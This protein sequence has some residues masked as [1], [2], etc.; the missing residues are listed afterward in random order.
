M[1]LLLVLFS[2]G[3]LI[4]NVTAINAS[5][6][7]AWVLVATGSAVAAVLVIAVVRAV[8]RIADGGAE[9]PWWLQIVELVLVGLAY[10]GTQVALAAAWEVELQRGAVLTV[11][12][13]TLEVTVIGAAVL[14]LIRSRRR[15]AAIRLQ[16]LEEAV[17]LSLARLEV[18]EIVQRMQWALQ[19]DIDSTLAAA[20]RSIEEQLEV[21]ERRTAFERWPAI[22]DHLRRTANDTVRPLSRRLWLQSTRDE[23]PLSLGRILRNVITTQPFRPGLLVLAYLATSLVTAVAGAGWWTALMVMGLGILLI[24]VI[25]GSA[26]RLMRR[27]PERHALLFITAAV[28]LELTGL[29][30]FPLRDRLGL[31][32]YTWGEFA[33]A[34]LVGMVFILM[35]SA[36]GSIRTYQQDVARTFRHDLDREFVDSL[37]AGR[38]VAQLAR[39]SARILHGSVQTRLVACAVAV[40][41]AAAANDPEA[42]RSAL[43]E[44]QEALTQPVSSLGSDSSSLEEEVARKVGLWRGLCEVSVSIDPDVAS[45]QGRLARNVARVVEEGIGNS[46]RHGNAGAVTVTVSGTDEGVEVVIEDDGDGP[47]GGPPGLGTAMLDGSSPGWSL[48]GLPRGSRLIVSLQA[49]RV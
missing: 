46:I 7:S 10:S 2:A 12:S 47:Q 4:T 49:D 32:P 8:H 40:E 37:A 33:A 34:F 35:T 14:A 21:V 25:L 9:A 26:N 11:V 24:V 27:L 39:E 44:A 31:P 36:L 22:A 38:Q 16:L 17:S 13:G 6:S 3:V 30:S 15:Q 5:P 1:A 29:I 43:T 28:V 19:A 42:L 18:A 48:V 41:R 45:G 23:S 20:R